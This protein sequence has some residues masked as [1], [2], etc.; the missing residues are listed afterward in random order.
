MI[1]ISLASTLFKII[2]RYVCHNIGILFFLKGV[3]WC[4]K[5]KEKYNVDDRTNSGSIDSWSFI[6]NC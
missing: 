3:F 2:V 6:L 1:A 4:S 5:F